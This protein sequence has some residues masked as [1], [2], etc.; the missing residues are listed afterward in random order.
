MFGTLLACLLGI[1]T[2]LALEKSEATKA[3]AA[4]R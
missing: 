3:K 2:T 1:I 4:R